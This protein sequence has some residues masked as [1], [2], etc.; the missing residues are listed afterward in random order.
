M[1]VLTLP[2]HPLLML[3]ELPELCNHGSI[4]L[5]LCFS[6]K[7]SKCVGNGYIK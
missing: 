3:K 7:V 5:D 2:Q 6:E 4:P 1:Q